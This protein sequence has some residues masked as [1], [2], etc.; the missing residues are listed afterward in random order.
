M[1]GIRIRPKDTDLIKKLM[2][3]DKS[4]FTVSDLEK[5]LGLKRE[6]LLVALTRLTKSGVLVRMKR[7]VYRTFTAYQNLEKIGSELYFPSYISFETALS[8]YGILSQMPYTVTFATQRASKKIAVGDSEIEYS[9][10]KKDLFFGYILENGIYIADI[11][12][13]LLDQL[14]MV[15]RGKRSIEIEELDLRDIN[16]DKLNDYAS[17]FPTYIHK[18]VRKVRRYIGST[19]I[20]NKNKERVVFGKYS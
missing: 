15:S 6:S 7:G 5:V 16:K 17:K 20:T 4:Y 12:K 18:L 19:P 3:L 10:I 1:A 13:A 14:Y 2:E 8:H 9:H 11:E